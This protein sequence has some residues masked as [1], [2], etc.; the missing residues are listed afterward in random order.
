MLQAFIII[1]GILIC[2][3]CIMPRR[4]KD[5]IKPVSL[6]KVEEYFTVEEIVEKVNYCVIYAHQIIADE[7]EYESLEEILRGETKHHI[8]NSH[9]K[10]KT[11]ADISTLFL[12]KNTIFVDDTKKR[13]TNFKSIKK[14]DLIRVFSREAIRKNDRIY[15]AVAEMVITNVKAYESATMGYGA[16]YHL[17]TE[18]HWAIFKTYPDYIWCDASNIFD[19]NEKHFH[20]NSSDEHH[21]Y[22]YVAWEN[23]E[24]IAEFPQQK[25]AEYWI[26]CNKAYLFE[27]SIE[28]DLLDTLMEMENSKPLKPLKYGAIHGYSDNLQVETSTQMA[29]SSDSID[30]FEVETKNSI[31]EKPVEVIKEKVIEPVQANV[32]EAVAKDN[33]V[34]YNT[35]SQTHKNDSIDRNS[36]IKKAPETLKNEEYPVPVKIV[37]A[38]ATTALFILAFKNAYQKQVQ[39][40]QKTKSKPK[41]KSK[42]KAKQKKK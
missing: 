10:P 13:I 27:R 14:G 24:P 35:Y 4:K 23:F 33:S 36:N 34:Q 22:L 17:D 28:A 29:M 5:E 2:F 25:K 41:T 3:L 37:S 15:H 18:K 30:A 9:S 12:T 38:V 1:A 16:T 6:Y 11:D 42:A 40:K 20:P 26:D 31:Q 8:G 32:E 7:S 21:K 19:K 39:T